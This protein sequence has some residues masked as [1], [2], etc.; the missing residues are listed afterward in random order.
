MKENLAGPVVHLG[1]LKREEVLLN[2]TGKLV[3]QDG[4]VI[5]VVHQYDRHKDV[6]QLLKKA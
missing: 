3:N 2:A 5:N 4:T 6:E 1:G